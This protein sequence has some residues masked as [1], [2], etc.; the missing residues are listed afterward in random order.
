MTAKD[1]IDNLLDEAGQIASDEVKRLA[2]KILKR[3]KKLDRFYM[4]MGTWFFIDKHG[5]NI[6][7]F[8]EEKIFEEIDS[9]ISEFDDVLH[10]T[11]ESI[12]IKLP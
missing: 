4:G 10:I 3:N 8:D 5:R 11:G 12:D 9:F 7:T 1:K 6:D 2:L